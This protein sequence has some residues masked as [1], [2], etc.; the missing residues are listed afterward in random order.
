MSQGNAEIITDLVDAWNGRDVNRFLR[1]FDADC[2]VVFRPEVPEP[3][4]FRGHAQLRE[5]AE[6]F[7][8]AWE[9]HTAE[10]VEL[11]EKG[12]SAVVVLRLVG[13]GTGSG[14]AM[15]ETDA[16]LFVF[17]EGRIAGWH[18]FGDREE[19]L[20]AAGLRE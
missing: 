18:N 4:P 9:S 10:V 12:D 8:A 6:G 20:E 15:E 1:L 19:A 13:R 16:H 11:L 14:I 2:E 5:W 17:R 7:L 3:G